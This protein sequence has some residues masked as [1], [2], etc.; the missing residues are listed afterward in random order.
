MTRTIREA[1][2]SKRHET[3][4]RLCLAALDGAAA[5]ERLDVRMLLHEAYRM[6]GDFRAALGALPEDDGRRLD[7]VLAKARDFHLLACEEF[8]RW[9]DQKRRGLTL[10]EYVEEMRAQSMAHFDRA[11]ELATAEDQVGRLAEELSR[12][13]H[14][15][16]AEKLRAAPGTAPPV[17]DRPAEGPVGRL[18]GT[19]RMPDGRPAADVGVCLGLRTDV[20]EADPTTYIE[21]HMHYLPH[22]GP[23]ETRCCRTD[24]EGRFRMEG[25][26]ADRHEFLAVM[27]DPAEHDIPTR[28]VAHGVEVAAGKETRLDLTVDEWRSA[29]PAT[30]E[31]PH[32]P[33]LTRGGREYRR[34]LVQRLSNP[35]HYD[36]PRQLVRLELPPGA[37]AEADRLL[38]VSDGAREPLA[39]QL[40]G[41]EV[42]F[43][44][45]LPAMTDRV[46]ALYATDRAAGE[47]P[48]AWMP[49]P[50]PDGAT[51]VIDSGRAAFR[52]P[53]GTGA[54]AP[55]PLLAVRGEDG[56]W[57]GQGRFRLPDGL[58]IVARETTVLE[59]G[60]LVLVVE[61][62]YRLSDGGRYS[63]VFTAHRGQPYLLAR[64]TSPPVEGAAFEFSLREFHGGRGFLHWTPES[65]NRHWSD[66]EAADRELARLQESVPFWVP[67]CGFAY[68]MTP[69]SPGERDYVGVFTI[70]RGEWIDRAF[71]RIAQGPG[72]DGRELDWPYPEMVGST[73]SMITANTTADGDALFRFRF[74]DGR[75]QW[76]I[77]VSTLDRNDGPF[78]E[79][80]AVQHKNS[81]PRLQDFKDW[82]LD[83][84]DRHL[85]PSVVARREDLRAIRRK[86]DSPVFAPVW[87][88][89]CSGSVGG[90]VAGVR[91][92]VDGDPAVAWRKARE[93]IGV[94]AIRSRM[95]LLGR[96][97]A[98][99]YN[100][101]GGRPITQWAEDY[102][103]I[104][105]SGVFTPDE[106]RQVRRFL[107]L[108]GYMYMEPDLMNWR[109]NSR[110][111]NFEADR[112]DVVGAVGLAMAGATDA[113]RFV[114]HAA[115]SLERALEVYCTPGSGKWYENP[116]CYYLQASKCRMNLAVHLAAHGL[117]DPTAI[118]RL[119]DF[120][121]WGVLLLTPPFPRSIE[122]IC[123]PTDD[124][125]YRAARRVRRIPPIGDH[126]RLGAWVPEHY[127]L[128]AKLYRAGDPELADL[129][130]WAYQ[131]GGSDGGYF[132]N[133]PLLFTSLD[134]GDLA[135]APPQTLTS[136]RLEGFGAVFRG[137][138]G[139]EEE[140]YLLFKQG[141]GGY[142]YHRTEGSILL[143]AD[144]KPLVYDGGEGGETW[145]HSTLSFHDVHMPLA[146]GH[147]ERFRSLPCLDFA[148]GVHPVALSPGEPAFLSDACDHE[149]VPLAYRRFA[150]PRPADSR[151]VI[152]VK[153]HYVILHDE[154]Q[155]DPGVRSHWHLQVVADD[156]TG[157][158]PDGYVF[159][160]RFG[161]DLQVLLPGQTFDAEAVEQLPI[162]EYRPGEMR[163][164]MRHLMLTGRRPDHYLAVLRPLS[165][166]TP[167]VEAEPLRADGRTVG[168]R[169]TGPGIDDRLFFS[170]RGAS[171][172]DGPVEFEGRYAA[173]LQHGPQTEL[174]LLDAG[175]LRL[176][177]ATVT[178]DGPVRTVRIPGEAPE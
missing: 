33:A 106:E 104:A 143:F 22:V 46:L 13:G 1:L 51:A 103:L 168:V 130:L 38:L 126:A 136:R 140:F 2:A 110:N 79:L 152:W 10:D 34:I 177:S 113:E 74:F 12:C 71:E 48:E 165:A 27:L 53:W 161:T 156:H 173:I 121:R 41:G 68:A 178:S 169:V 45:D 39:V 174:I 43:F 77:L 99:M 44:T 88:R 42:A 8:Y 122:Q 29:P 101:V 37:P 58:R 63:L 163:F 89:I 171:F 112:T 124:A 19:L 9:S 40:I 127:A 47:R 76:G 21:P 80:S 66:L 158:W 30:V 147:V 55:A 7:V 162:H 72:D 175:N 135:P 11:G 24:A 60:P 111:A 107:M 69:D 159:R 18:A 25:V 84:Q 100:P 151:S 96:D 155:I 5:E 20:H 31:N 14:T 67:P 134:E 54:D 129:L 26:P 73:I 52:L 4:R 160:G 141:P 137:G 50:Q 35:F 132:G 36:F 164:T 139:A 144:G 148:Q 94:A 92:A 170:R 56:V 3:A 157:R 125:T 102:D 81:S 116:P 108:M 98:D 131:Q 118:P 49:R 119:K 149:L 172:R 62:S 128:M 83:E 65:G 109:F 82:R 138:F 153:G 91:F 166:G 146:A 86:K 15:D 28:F 32:P 167:P 59:A 23:L 90:P 57:R 70:R 142:R 114:E 97:H 85:R 117:A 93:L 176:G 17:E 61:V 145:R 133:L 154:L 123:T 75:R 87:E 78:K 95:T 120:L 64:E 150:E 105:A 115:A 16:A 6:L